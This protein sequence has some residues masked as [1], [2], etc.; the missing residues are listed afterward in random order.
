MLN[1]TGSG[2]TNQ[3][4]PFYRNGGGGSGG[5]GTGSGYV[6]GRSTHIHP[7]MMLDPASGF[8]PGYGGGGNNNYGQ[9]AGMDLMRRQGS[10][11]SSFSH[12]SSEMSLT[13][14]QH[15]D[16]AGGGA[17]FGGGVGV[18]GMGGPGPGHGF[19]GGS[20]GG[21]GGAIGGGMGGG[22][23]LYGEAHA[24]NSLQR[25]SSKP[26]AFAIKTNVMY[27][28]G[29]DDDSPVHGTAVSFKIGDYLHIYE[30]YNAN[31]W[32]GRIVKEGCENG[33]IPSPA[34]LEQLI[35][36]Q[37]PMGKASKKGTQGA[38]VC[39]ATSF[40]LQ[41]YIARIARNSGRRRVLR[42]VPIIICRFHERPS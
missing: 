13:E 39:I 11:E 28:G 32:I 40:C 14:A 2:G 17:G 26:V 9:A 23:E 38:G 6:S 30:K 33:F 35:L 8:G 42:K 19:G 20:G 10:A 16:A 18:G 34:K 4:L 15:F 41:T 29:Q 21:G 5:T 25:A 31:W 22:A 36:Q 3:Q 12:P 24:M 27:D 7:N 1:L 37:A